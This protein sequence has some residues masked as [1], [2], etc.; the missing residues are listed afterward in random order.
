MKKKN[1][2]KSTKPKANKPQNP[3]PNMGKT[4]DKPLSLHG[5]DF[6]NLV[7]IALKNKKKEK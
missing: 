2:P 7:D 6:D 4:Y 3:G 5:M 1:K